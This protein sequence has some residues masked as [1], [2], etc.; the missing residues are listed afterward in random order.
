MSIRTNQLLNQNK[1]SLRAM[2]PQR[3]RGA[4]AIMAAVLL[5]VLLAVG[6][7]VID[8]ANLILVKGELQNAADSAAQA[9][10]QCLYPRA[11]ETNCG[12]VLLTERPN[13]GAAKDKANDAATS[14]T[15]GNAVQGRLVTD[16]VVD[17]GYWNVE[18]KPDTLQDK[19]I[20]PK[21]EDYPA[22]QVTISKESGKNGGGVLF[23][24]AKIMALFGTTGS[25]AM[26]LD[27]ANIS[28]TAV[29]VVTPPGSVPP[30]TLFPFAMAKCMYDAFWA[31][32]QP[33]RFKA[34]DKDLNGL[35]ELQTVG[36]P[37][38]FHLGWYDS[39]YPFKTPDDVLCDAGQW[40]PFKDDRTGANIVD[41]YI[42]QS[43][44]KQTQ[45]Q[46]PE[47]SIDDNIYIR[48]GA[49]DVLYQHTQSCSLAGDK[50]CG[51]ATIA[52]TAEAKDG[53]TSP[54]K[55]FGCLKILCA[56]SGGGNPKKEE[57]CGLTAKEIK[58]KT[59][60]KRFIEVQMSNECPPPQGGGTGP[61]NGVLNPPRL[62]F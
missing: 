37:W 13:F 45:T 49:T 31:S 23:Y 14:A 7:L 34:G 32:G 16:A 55:A 30:G 3:Q 9:G 17:V 38:K 59:N 57:T 61:D 22:V 4:I 40:T 35:Q 48:T 8:I 11:G 12:V 46:S 5:P 42:P 52:V 28:A 33:I 39:K 50:T 20:T 54:I 10:A 27:T 62:A 29:S 36:Q 51:Y 26:G 44:S 56:N 21:A 18:R 43:G 19:G 6:A 15:Q 58:N 53:T 2:A 41:G 47:L 1:P 25:T 24:L 60:T